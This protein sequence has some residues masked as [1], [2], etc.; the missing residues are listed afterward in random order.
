V[1]NLGAESRLRFF[2]NTVLRKLFGTQEGGS[3]G[4]VDNIKCDERRDL[5]CS[6]NIIG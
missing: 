4:K 5:Y 1:F 6:P 2:E 3:N